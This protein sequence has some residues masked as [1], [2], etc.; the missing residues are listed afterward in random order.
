MK[1][2]HGLFARDWLLSGVIK[3]FEEKAEE[4]ES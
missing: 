4:G 2:A 3:L 1:K